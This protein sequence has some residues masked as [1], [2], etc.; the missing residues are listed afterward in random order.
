MR[1]VVLIVVVLIV[2]GSL[3]PWQFHAVHLGS[4]PLWI[5]L[6]SWP[7]QINR[8]L[9]WDI[10]V[11]VALYMPLGVFGF[12]AMSERAP[13]MA[14]VCT[15]ILFALAL[16]AS[17][18]MLQ[19]FDTS[20]QCS[21]SDVLCNVTGAAVGVAFGLLYR[22]K[23]HGV[24]ERRRTA[25]FLQLSGALLLLGCWFC[26]QLL[27]LF[28][29]LGRMKLAARLR[30]LGPISTISPIE[31]LIVCTEWLAVACLLDRLI[32][33]ESTR[34]LTA[35]LVVI[36]A[37]LLIVSRTLSWADIAGAAAAYAMWIWLPRAYL[38]RAT[39]LLLSSA[40]V[41]GELTPFHFGRARDFNWVPFR[42]LLQASWQ[43]SFVLLFR[44]CFWYG[45]VMWLWRA[46]GYR[47][48]PIV[49]ATA[50]ALLALEWAQTFLEGR[51]PEITDAL[52]ALLMGVVLSQIGAER[53]PAPP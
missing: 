11:N 52:L 22:E 43:S 23:L 41:L 34:L 18:E 13:R 53:K 2:Y 37:R 26:Y 25:H 47:F 48:G 28:P 20:R 7:D 14:R 50:A 27:P 51:T 6:H 44:K 46:K 5:L 30:A 42:G 39:P 16:S 40:L 49:L 8:Y 1:R 36:P 3:Y 31:T 17:I 15:P 21:A 24:L 4:S 29:S 12:L 45:S 9:L 10:A 19:L 32:E 38:R 33:E 35:L